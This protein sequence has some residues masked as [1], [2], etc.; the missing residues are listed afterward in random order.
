[1]KADAD[2]A[3]EWRNGIKNYKKVKKRVKFQ[4]QRSSSGNEDIEMTGASG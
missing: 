1:M 3:Q 4:G 2:Q